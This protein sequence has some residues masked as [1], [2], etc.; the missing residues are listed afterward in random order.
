MGPPRLWQL[1]T[2]LPLVL[3]GAAVASDSADSALEKAARVRIAQTHPLELH[4]EGFVPNEHVT[5]RIELG[6]KIV[7][8]SLRA[9]ATGTFVSKYAGLVLDRCSKRLAVNA[10]GAHGDRAEFVLQTLPCP[11]GAAR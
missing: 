8:R 6:S 10:V 4:G 5:L 7:K 11:N 3:C 1:V 2:L 9:S